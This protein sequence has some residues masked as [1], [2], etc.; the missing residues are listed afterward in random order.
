MYSNRPDALDASAATVSV[1]RESDFD[2]H[3]AERARKLLC[4]TLLCCQ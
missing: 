1:Y 4:K 2:I 3:P